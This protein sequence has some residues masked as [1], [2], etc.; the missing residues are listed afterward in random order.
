MRIPFAK[1]R[2]KGQLPAQQ[3]YK[4]VGPEVR[5]TMRKICGTMPEDMKPEESLKKPERERKKKLPKPP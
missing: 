2:V 3:T 1:N 5:T 4:Q